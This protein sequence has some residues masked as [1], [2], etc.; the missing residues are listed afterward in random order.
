LPD[1]AA[2]IAAFLETIGWGGVPRRVLAAD[3]S[4][5]RYD[6]LQEPARRAVLMDAPP[7]QEDV[8]PFLAV[9]RLLH[10][11]GIS[12][13]QIFAEDVAAG[14]LL[15]EDFGDDT[16]TRLLAAGAEGTPLYTLAIDVL[17]AIHRNFTP[18]MA[19]FVT[20]YD[21]E[22]LLGEVAELVDWY[23]PAVAGGATDAALRAE[24]LDLWRALL[25]LARGVPETL[26]LRDFHVDNLMLLGGRSGTAACGVLDFQ[27]AAI[28]PC[29]YDVMSLLMDERRDVPARLA[30]A[31]RRRYLE[32]FPELDRE[33]F[34]ASYAV[35]GGL[36]HCKNIGRFARLWRRDGKPGYLVHIPRVWGLVEQDLRHPALAAVAA[37][38]AQHIPPEL[39]RVPTVEAAR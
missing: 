10:R 30:A 21:D 7:P 13:P 33:R 39:R 29:S 28:G 19:P 31:M 16:Y 3:A 9:A 15:L 20:R 11:L 12:A 32:A 25:P 24:Y 5:R 38:L 22:R 18:A 27:D 1:R 37:W 36:R 2:Q 17:I 26:V 34:A 8:R 14:L 23:R 35:L 4:F 6:R